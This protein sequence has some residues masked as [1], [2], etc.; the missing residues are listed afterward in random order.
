MWQISVMKWGRRAILS[1][2]KRQ[3]CPV[4]ARVIFS[5]PL[6]RQMRAQRCGFSRFGEKAS[7]FIKKCILKSMEMDIPLT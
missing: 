6:L 3:G 4:P 7:A 2:P 5:A 1:R